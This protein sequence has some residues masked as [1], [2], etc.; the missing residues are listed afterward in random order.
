[1]TATRRLWETPAGLFAW[2][3]LVGAASYGVFMVWRQ[4]REY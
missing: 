2:F 1:V 3:L 4:W